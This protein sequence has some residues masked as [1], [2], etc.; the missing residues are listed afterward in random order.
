MQIG[1]ECGNG[2]D[3]GS[4]DD[5]P[6]EA[7]SAWNR[8]RR[9]IYA[10]ACRTLRQIALHGSRRKVLVASRSARKRGEHLDKPIDM[11]CPLVKTER[12]LASTAP[13]KRPKGC[14]LIKRGQP[15]A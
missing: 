4:K 8:C 11:I 5:K 7:G 9:G 2:P 12:S 15:I 3:P 14:I 10:F 1:A 13:Q 6:L